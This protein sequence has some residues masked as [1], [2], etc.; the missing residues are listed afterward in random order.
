MR[1]IEVAPKITDEMLD[2]VRLGNFVVHKYPDGEQTLYVPETTPVS[3]F[4]SE[5]DTKRKL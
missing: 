2:Q 1:Y 4:S 3:F 5:I